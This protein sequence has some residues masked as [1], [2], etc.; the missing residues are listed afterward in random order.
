MIAHHLAQ[1]ANVDP[2]ISLFAHVHVRRGKRHQFALRD[3]LPGTP[4]KHDKSI[5]SAA[6]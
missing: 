2:K 6:A 3:H 5:Q 1:S 4:E